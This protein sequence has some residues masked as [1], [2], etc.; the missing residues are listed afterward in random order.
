MAQPATQKRVSAAV[1]YSGRFY[2]AMTPSAWIDNH[3]RSLI[4]PNRASVVVVADADNWCD[5]GNAEVV[6]ALKS[7]TE[8]GF[9]RASKLFEEQV[10]S[11]FRQ[12]PDVRA[13]LLRGNSSATA[14]VQRRA[15]DVGRSEF[16]HASAS[17]RRT[18]NVG[19]SHRL[20]PHMQRWYL[21]YEHFARAEELRRRSGGAHDVVVR[22]RVDSTLSTV[23]NLS[24]PRYAHN[25]SIV[26]APSFRAVNFDGYN[27]RPCTREDPPTPDEDPLYELHHC[28]RKYRDYLM[29]GTHKSI[30]TLARMVER[31]LEY[32]GSAPLMRCHAWCEEEQTKLQLLRQN[33]SLAPLGGRVVVELQQVRIPKQAAIEGGVP[34]GGSGCAVGNHRKKDIVDR[35]D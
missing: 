19:L 26:H 12:W 16:P 21:Q 34:P 20:I 13:A 3:M 6:E 5:H 32:G 22:A 29:V 11:V 8:A 14:A 35:V 23:L 28:A 25:H 24:D 18:H 10:R 17:M 27:E 30:K 15:K 7:R 4:V 31:R 1:L 2:G 9:A 33:V